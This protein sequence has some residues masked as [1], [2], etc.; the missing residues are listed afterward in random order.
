M[1]N[2]SRTAMA[3]LGCISARRPWTCYRIVILQWL[4]R[5]VTYAKINVKAKAFESRRF[6]MELDSFRTEYCQFPAE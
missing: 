2:S 5:T 1:E 3:V 6:E 4:R